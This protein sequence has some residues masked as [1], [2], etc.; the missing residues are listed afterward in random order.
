MT[1]FRAPRQGHGL[2]M[3]VS[4]SKIFMRE[5]G[6]LVSALSAGFPDR[7]MAVGTFPRIVSR[8][9]FMVLARAFWSTI[10]WSD[11]NS[12]VTV[13]VLDRD[14]AWQAACSIRET[15]I[16]TSVFWDSMM[17]LNNQLLQC[18]VDCGQTDRTKTAPDIM[19]RVTREAAVLVVDD[20][21][22]DLL[23]GSDA[24]MTSPTAESVHPQSAAHLRI[25]LLPLLLHHMAVQA[26]V[27]AMRRYAA[28]LS[29]ELQRVD[30]GGAAQT[31][32]RVSELHLADSFSA[33]FI[34]VAEGVPVPALAQQMLRIVMN[35]PD[36]RTLHLRRSDALT[37]RLTS[38][39]QKLVER[40]M[41]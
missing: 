6:D 30:E 10:V 36:F 1:L 4:Q 7:S 33:S 32:A 11:E 40:M 24:V 17:R 37:T 15:R 9:E 25:S 2:G 12:S 23:T 5:V 38:T 39:V 26:L 31:A 16:V 13:S 35:S 21:F 28:A 20:F 19:S 14:G 29:D 41:S 22:A 18:C 27:L 3:G 34:E 8:V